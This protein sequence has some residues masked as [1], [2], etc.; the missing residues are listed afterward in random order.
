MLGVA[1]GSTLACRKDDMMQHPCQ[2]PCSGYLRSL[3][4]MINFQKT[5]HLKLW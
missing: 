3:P 2:M 5:P 4:Q 1:K